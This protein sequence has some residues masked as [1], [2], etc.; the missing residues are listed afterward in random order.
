MGI[1]LLLSNG[2][3]KGHRMRPGRVMVA[4]RV[5]PVAGATE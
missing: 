2:L 5:K 3:K 1:A 4:F